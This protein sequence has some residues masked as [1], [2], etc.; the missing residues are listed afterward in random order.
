MALPNLLLFL[1]I[2]GSN[3]LPITGKLAS[4][5][6]Y[7]CKFDICRSILIT[8]LRPCNYIFNQGTYVETNVFKKEWKTI[9]NIA[10]T[11]GTHW[12]V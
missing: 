3:V 8:I 12:T 1:F 7:R 9:Y 6:A 5:C 11:S 10:K 4:N 2:V